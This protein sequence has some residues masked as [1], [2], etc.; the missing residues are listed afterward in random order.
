[1]QYM[2]SNILDF[3]TS[4]ARIQKWVHRQT[5]RKSKESEGMETPKRYYAEIYTPE[6]GYN[7]KPRLQYFETRED[8]IRFVIFENEKIRDLSLR[9]KDRAN[10][11][12]TNLE[13]DW[14]ADRQL[15]KKCFEEFERGK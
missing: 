5:V 13:S 10:R 1:M 8:A 4:V 7:Q 6:K 15:V 11:F 9:E 3:S 14:S 2:Y 12:I